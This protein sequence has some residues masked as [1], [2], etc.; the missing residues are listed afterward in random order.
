MF[1]LYLPFIKT[2]CIKI[3]TQMCF[4]IDKSHSLR[5]I[6]ILWWTLLFL[7]FQKNLTITPFP[8]KSAYISHFK[9]SYSSHFKVLNSTLNL[10]LSDFT[11]PTSKISHFYLLLFFFLW[12][13]VSPKVPGLIN[14]NLPSPLSQALSFFSKGSPIVASHRATSWYMELARQITD[15]KRTFQ[16]QEEI[17]AM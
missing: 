14:E 10:T 16:F 1:G 17:L 5:A 9:Y 3:I 12:E 7:A 13:R 8:L 2:L 11:P 4:I 6:S 15:E